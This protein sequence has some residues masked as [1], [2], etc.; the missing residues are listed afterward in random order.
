MAKTVLATMAGRNN[1]PLR[2]GD[3]V[4]PYWGR[5]NWTLYRVVELYESTEEL[6]RAGMREG[7]VAECVVILR[8]NGVS[9][10][11]GQRKYK[12][13]P[14]NLEKVTEELIQREI[15]SKQQE[16]TARA[17]AVMTIARGLT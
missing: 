9:V 7:L 1:V 12:M 16:L 3:I 8:N 5:G 11:K 4:R 17:D 2:V 6:R 14:Q 10:R 15:A 13:H